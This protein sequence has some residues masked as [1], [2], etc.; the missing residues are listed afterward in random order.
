MNNI[1]KIFSLPL[2]VARVINGEFEDIE[3]HIIDCRY[4]FEYKGGHIQVCIHCFPP[5][6]ATLSLR[7]T[8]HMKYNNLVSFLQNFYF[9]NVKWSSNL[10]QIR[11]VFWVAWMGYTANMS[12]FTAVA[13]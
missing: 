5:P 6:P 2:Q 10:M 8:L 7:D 11:Q 4:P 12:S 3:A 1:N 13:Y 9:Y